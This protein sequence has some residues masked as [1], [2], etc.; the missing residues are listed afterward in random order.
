MALRDWVFIFRGD[1]HDPAVQT[2][3]FNAG[4]LR[5]RIVGV[6]SLDQAV[7]VARELAADGIQMIEL[8][9]F[10]GAEGASRIAEAVGETV[11][12]GFVTPAPET[13]GLLAGIFGES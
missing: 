7:E 5:T 4:G 2:S 13:S 8:C 9:G 10:F 11:A 12:V 3:E 6:E 1:D